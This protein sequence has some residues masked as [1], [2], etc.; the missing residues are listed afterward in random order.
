M[1]FGYSYKSAGM[2]KYALYIISVFVNTNFVVFL[3]AS[4]TNAKWHVDN[5]F[6]HG[7]TTE[8]Q[9]LTIPSRQKIEALPIYI[10][11]YI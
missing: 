6:V 3:V 7:A 8:W 2:D 4:T 9:A 1:H 11:I 5:D 10:Y